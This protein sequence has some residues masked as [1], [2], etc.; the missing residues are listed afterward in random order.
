GPRAPWQAAREQPAL[1][2]LHERPDAGDLCRRLKLHRPTN[3]IPVL[4]TSACPVAALVVAPDECLPEPCPE[5]FAATAARL[6]RRRRELEGDGQRAEVRFQVSGDPGAL[7]ELSELLQPWFA[8]C[9]LTPF[10]A[11]QFNLAVRE[12]VANAVEWG[13]GNAPD[14][15][16]SVT[17][18]LESDR[19]GVLVRD[20]G[21]GFDRH[22]LPHAARPGDPLSHLPVRAARQ[23]REGGFGILMA[24]GLV[25]HL[26]YNDV[27]NEA[28]LIK[29]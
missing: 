22:N 15:P 21:P 26:C 9:D 27:G 16:V 3:L 5:R 25:D 7:E 6:L 14:R 24:T 29:F 8:S 19:V 1:I 20:T 10:Q 28:S 12:V 4:Q 23:L 18:R 2:V 13:H 17:C 11:R